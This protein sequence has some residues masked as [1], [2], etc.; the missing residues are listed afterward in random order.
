MSSTARSGLR[1][2][3]WN[4]RYTMTLRD[5][6]YEPNER[7]RCDVPVD[8]S[9]DHAIASEPVNEGGRRG[10]AGSNATSRTAPSNAGRPVL[11]IV[12]TASFDLVLRGAA[13]G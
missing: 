5:E 6:T 2:S 4:D 13:A 7:A 10:E 9:Q 1:K 3:E 11:E 8:A 12:V